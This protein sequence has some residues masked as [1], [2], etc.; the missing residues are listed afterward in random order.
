MVNRSWF[1]EKYQSGFKIRREEIESN[2]KKKMMKTCIHLSTFKGKA[3]L[4]KKLFYEK[5]RVCTPS[6]REFF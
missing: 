3:S 4:N 5:S 1:L 6:L 2:V